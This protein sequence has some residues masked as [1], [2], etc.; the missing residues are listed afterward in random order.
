M[1][2]NISMETNFRGDERRLH[3]GF[4]GLVSLGRGRT[5]AKV[6]CPFCDCVVSCFVWSLCGSGK[7]CSCGAVIYRTAALMP[8]VKI[9]S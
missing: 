8:K 1:V 9:K 7:K 2:K 6:I 4:F 5:K 3:N